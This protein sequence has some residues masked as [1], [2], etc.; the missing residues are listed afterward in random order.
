MAAWGG[1]AVIAAA[2]AGGIAGAVV[3]GVVGAAGAA[4]SGGAAGRYQVA[5]SGSAVLRLDTTTGEVV[6]CLPV[7]GS[8]F[9]FDCWDQAIRA[10][11]E[12]AARITARERR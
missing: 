4:G 9:D 1:P 11:L 2:V 12:E 8:H 10:R 7:S 3:A 5:V 6:A